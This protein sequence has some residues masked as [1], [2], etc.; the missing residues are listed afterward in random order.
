MQHELITSFGKWK[1]PFDNVNHN[2][3][4]VIV[5]K[6]NIRCTYIV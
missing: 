6:Y 1:P 3:D 4:I 5:S 2:E